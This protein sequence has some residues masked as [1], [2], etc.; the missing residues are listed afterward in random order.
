MTHPR[1]LSETAII[2]LN[3][4]TVKWK[5]ECNFAASAWVHAWQH[6]GIAATWA[7]IPG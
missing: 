3:Y 4:C 5:V 6:V 7:S 1:D 2:V